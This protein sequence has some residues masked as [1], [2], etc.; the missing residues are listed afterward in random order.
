MTHRVLHIINNATDCVPQVRILTALA[1]ALDS[2][3][4]SLHCCFLNAYGPLKQELE[5]GGVPVSDLGGKQ[6]LRSVGTAGQLFRL[7]KDGRFEMVHDHYG[8]I[9][10]R[11]IARAAGARSILHVHSRLSSERDLKPRPRSAHL[12][13]SVIATSA[14]AAKCIRASN[15]TVIY[16]GANVT[17]ASGTPIEKNTIGTVARLTP[18]KGLEYLIDAISLVRWQIHDVQ[19]QIV[20]AGPLRES[21]EYRVEDLGLQEHVSFTG[22]KPDVGPYMASWKLFVLPSIEE[23]FGVS[24]L[25]AMAAGL[26]VVASDV[27]GIPEVVVNGSTGLL[28]P[29]GNSKKLAEAILHLLKGEQLRQAMSIAAVERVRDHFSR[30]RMV[31]QI[32]STYERV[33]ASRTE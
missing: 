33:M 6:N 21:L 13:N 29:P 18:V 27:G 19:L 8:G 1:E 11:V 28:V 2:T 10:S 23:A 25:E 5:N 16:P 7:I 22:W 32:A 30:E 17:R 3:R 31:E 15:V 26:P 12:A 20:G 24:I 14:A 4:Y 9:L